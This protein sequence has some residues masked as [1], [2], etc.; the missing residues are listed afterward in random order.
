MTT[1]YKEEHMVIELGKMSVFMGKISK[2][3]D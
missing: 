2:R 3:K 1:T